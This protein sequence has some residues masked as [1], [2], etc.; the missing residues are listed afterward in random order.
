MSYSSI[1]QKDLPLISWALDDATLTAGSTAATDGFFGGYDG[2]TP[3]Y[4]GSYVTACTAKEVP[5]IFGSTQSVIITHATAG[6]TV[7]RVP[8]LDRMSSKFIDEPSTLEFWLKFTNP[9]FA[10]PTTITKIV[11]KPNSQTGV[12][13]HNSSFIGIIGDTAGN[14]VRVSVPVDDITKTF[15]IALIY[16]KT[17]VSLS[18]N[19][20]FVS[21]SIDSNTLNKSYSSGDEY[22]NFV[23]PASNLDYAL[24]HVSIYSRALT[25][26]ECRKHLVYGLGYEISNQVANSFGGVR[27]NMSMAQSEVIGSYQK[28][29]DSTWKDSIEI[30]NLDVKNGILVPA[31]AQEP[32]LKY[33]KD[34]TSSVFTWDTYGVSCAA[35]GYIELENV[36]SIINTASFGYGAVFDRASGSAIT[37]TM[38]LAYFNDPYDQE[39]YIKFYIVGNGTREDL[40]YQRDDRTPT[41]LLSNTAGSING[42][43][44]CG[45]FYNATTNTIT[46]YAGKASS[47]TGNRIVSDTSVTSL[48][49]DDI[50]IGSMPVYSEFDNYADIVSGE[51]ERFIGGLKN[52]VHIPSA[53]SDTSSFSTIHTAIKTAPSTS[54]RTRYFAEAD[55]TN[56]RFIIKLVGKYEFVVDLKQLCG[57]ASVVGINKAEWGYSGQ[58]VSVSMTGIEDSAGVQSTWLASASISNGSNLTGIY[59]VAPGTSK[60]LKFTI[61]FV[62]NDVVENPTKLMYFRITT[63]R[64]TEP[65]SGTYKM[66]LVADGP[67]IDIYATSSKN[68]VILPSTIETPFLYDNERG[69][70]FIPYY[71]QIDYDYQTITSDATTGI[72]GI[73]M[74]VNIPSGADRYLFS[75]VSSDAISTKLYEL[76]YTTATGQLSLSTGTGTISVNGSSLAST[77]AI[78]ANRWQ[79]VVV[80]FGTQVQVTASKYPVIILGSK[81]QT[82]SFYL[83]ELMTFDNPSMTATE[84]GYIN[85]IYKGTNTVQVGKGTYVNSVD[86][87]FAIYDNEIG[88]SPMYQP[89]SGQTS[90]ATPVNFASTKAFPRTLTGTTG[91]LTF[92]AGAT[93]QTLSLDG[94][95]IDAG[96]RILL[97]NQSTTSQNGIFTVIGPV[98]KNTT[99]TLSRVSAPV[100]TLVY[101]KEGLQNEGA[102]YYHSSTDV[103]TKTYA[104]D[105]IVS[106]SSVGNA[107]SIPNT[108]FIE[109]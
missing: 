94:T 6:T 61:N 30:D 27:Y 80:V 65:T 8:S 85:K 23:M 62:S 15:H 83:D 28:G 71:A 42:E 87:A 4:T 82:S 63:Y 96:D 24:D 53:I 49:V 64:T 70:L 72:Y 67:D 74:F 81:T 106:Y 75:V 78:T 54:Y 59:N 7:F 9:S 97:K 26:Q 107:I 16:N 18:V 56:K 66:T 20:T 102:Y 90:V 14:V 48:I 37:G 93:L 34:K 108:S 68:A 104:L 89:I 101:V 5:I 33:A 35:G 58:E 79:H 13:I 98:A 73:S 3:L 77:Q 10:S 46:G 39:R 44:S 29:S 109:D 57:N 1:I 47:G 51:D 11:G 19:G 40:Y 12:Y 36:K 84:I 99:V 95:I 69:G 103:W 45:F 25:I 50:R 52:I 88:T 41:I 55:T 91:N 21:R 60:Y 100:G 38:T 32:K 92:P 76:K 105:K 86:K 2:Q 43:F 22:F 31:N 17:S